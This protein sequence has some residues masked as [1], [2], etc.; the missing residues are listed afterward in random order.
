MTQET[1]GMAEEMVQGAVGWTKEHGRA[2]ITIKELL[3]AAM[4]GGR[5]AGKTERARGNNMA[6]V[7]VVNARSSKGQDAMNLLR[8]LAFLG[9]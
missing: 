2:E 9:T 6:V 7:A 1:G 8:S 5:W 4:W 3:L